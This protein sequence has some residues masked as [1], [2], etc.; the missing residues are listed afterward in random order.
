MRCGHLYRYVCVRVPGRFTC[1]KTINSA[2]RRGTAS[3]YIR[4]AANRCAHVFE[5]VHVQQFHRKMI[6]RL[7]ARRAFGVHVA[8]QKRTRA[9]SVVSNRHIAIYYVPLFGQT[10]CVIYVVSTIGRVHSLVAAAQTRAQEC[11]KRT[12]ARFGARL[13]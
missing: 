2:L 1:P 6:S 10:A 7:C 9:L 11:S 8:C 3:G 13:D 5:C 12:R 4:G